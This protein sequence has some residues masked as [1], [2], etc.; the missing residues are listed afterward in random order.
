MKKWV[1]HIVLILLVAVNATG[2][3]IGP[4]GTVGWENSHVICEADNGFVAVTYDADRVYDLNVWDRGGWI[5]LGSIDLLPKHGSNPDGEFEVQD[6]RSFN[7]KIYVA[8][9]YVLK[10][11]GNTRNY[12]VVWDGSSWTDLN[13]TLVTKSADVHGLV[14]MNNELFLVGMFG[15]TSVTS[16]LLK[17]NP[18]QSW[19]EYGDLLTGDAAS[20][21]INDAHVIDNKLYLSGGFTVPKL[22]GQKI[23]ASLDNAKWV[24]ESPVPFQSG[25]A[26]FGVY[27]GNLV[28]LGDPTI[29]TYDYFRYKENA[30]W[31]NMSAGL[32]EVEVISVNKL[33]QIKDKLWASGQFKN[34][35]DSEIFNL[36]YFDGTSWTLAS[37]GQISNDLQLV[38]QSDRGYIYGN[39]NF[40]SVTNFGMIYSD[41]ALL[42]GTIYNDED[43]NC[44]KGSN[45]TG[46]ENAMV[47]LVGTD[48]V[49]IVNSDG[50][51]NI[52]VKAGD[53]TIRVVTPLYWNSPCTS[54]RQVSV[55]ELTSYSDLDF[56]IRQIPDKIDIDGY[57][58]DFNGWVLQ[59]GKEGTISF[60]VSNKGTADA[61]TVKV[62][63]TYNSQLSGVRFDP[64]PLSYGPG[65]AEWELSSLKAGE[66]KCFMLTALVPS[67]VSGDLKFDYEILLPDDTD[68]NESDNTGTTTVSTTSDAIPPLYK[69]MRGGAKLADNPNQ[70]AYKI[71]FQNTGTST[72]NRVVVLDTFDKDIYI[73]VEGVG[74]SYPFGQKPELRMEY[75]EVGDNYQWIYTWIWDGISFPDSASNPDKSVGFVDV[76]INLFDGMHPKGTEICNQAQVKYDNNEPGKTN[77][78]CATVGD[79]SVPGSPNADPFSVRP[80]PA[81]NV[82]YVQNPVSETTVLTLISTDGRVVRKIELR[83]NEVQEIDIS[84]LT[85]GVYFLTAPGYSATRVLKSSH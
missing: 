36:M 34:L 56:G 47:E 39:F 46:V 50:S 81:S 73:D 27:D 37:A 31:Y 12:V 1:L 11:T 75:L 69:S 10:L 13:H 30:S 55:T 76:E 33:T 59:K 35:S 3:G 17:L 42:S 45:E 54:T 82:I 26:N 58:T 64:A 44:L 29:N 67:D 43:N 71:R 18:D 49:F 28:L 2:Q 40:A 72:I 7:G 21:F 14:E 65:E 77:Q 4:A 70:V 66:T 80:N 19:S 85:N 23:L 5:Q 48:L 52:P 41:H 79:V 8:G 22:T 20:D 6:V 68:E 16:N 24:V 15:T 53:Y 63:L 62:K 60:C 38:A 78:V 57:I 9:K 84:G 61:G 51:Y 74:F 25:A 83:A 32:E